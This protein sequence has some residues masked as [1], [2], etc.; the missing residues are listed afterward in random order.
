MLPPWRMG[1]TRRWRMR[2]GP[3]RYSHIPGVR[4][5]HIP[6]STHVC[7]CSGVPRTT[8][9][10][11]LYIIRQFLLSIVHH[12]SC[13]VILCFTRFQMS[14]VQ[15]QSL[16]E[17]PCDVV[18]LPN[19]IPPVSHNQATLPRDCVSNTYQVSWCRVLTDTEN[20]P[21]WSLRASTGGPPGLL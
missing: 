16:K 7:R 14:D 2:I 21:G 17:C 4:L 11:C 20:I 13:N 15:Q 8:L 10:V 18:T 6:Q 3:H 5:Q 1:S 12:L 19:T 9:G